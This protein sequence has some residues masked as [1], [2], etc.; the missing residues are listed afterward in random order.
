[1]EGAWQMLQLDEPDD[2]VL[3]TGEAHSVEEFLEAAFS[4][5]G[6]DWHDYVEIDERYF[7]PAEVDL[8]IG[9][10]SKAKAK[11]GWEPT[12]RFRELVHMMVDADRERGKLEEH[13]L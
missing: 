8:L 4:H 12:V 13:Y 10:Y 9:D 1:M 3:A 7:R 6:L 5:A 2:F 11:L